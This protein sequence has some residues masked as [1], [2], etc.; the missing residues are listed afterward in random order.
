MWALRPLPSTLLIQ[1]IVALYYGAGKGEKERSA[2][3]Y[4]SRQAVRRASS[5]PLDRREGFCHK[6]IQGLQAAQSAR[7]TASFAQL[8]T[9]RRAAGGVFRPWTVRW[10]G[11]RCNKHR[12]HYVIGKIM[13]IMRIQ[14]VVARAGYDS[15]C[16]VV[17]GRVGGGTVVGGVWRV[18]W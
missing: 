4:S 10:E 9:E 1:S 8:R 18:W 2:Q 17:E 13:V 14:E 12:G 3:P 11:V 7:G 15:S 6:A 5:G 16:A